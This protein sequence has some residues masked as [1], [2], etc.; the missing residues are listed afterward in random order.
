[1]GLERQGGGRP[2]LAGWPHSRSAPLVTHQGRLVEMGKVPATGH[3]QD[4]ITEQGIGLSALGSAQNPI[5]LTP[6][7]TNRLGRQ[8]L[9]TGGEAA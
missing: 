4:G 9:S 5:L 3:G 1:M 6:E 2:R 7:H 8:G